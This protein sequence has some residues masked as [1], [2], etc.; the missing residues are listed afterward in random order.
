MNDVKSQVK[1]GASAAKAVKAVKAVKASD[2]VKQSKQNYE[3]KRD[4][5][6]YNFAALAYLDSWHGLQDI[7]DT[8]EPF[9]LSPLHDSDIDEDGKPKK[10]HY[11][12][13]F[14][15]HAQRSIDDFVNFCG[16]HGLVPLRNQYGKYIHVANPIGYARYLIH[17][18][19]PH[20][21]QYSAGEVQQF[22]GIQDYI[23]YISTSADEDLQI[24]LITLFI[25]KYPFCKT[26]S[27]W[28]M[29][30]FNTHPEWVHVF[31]TNTIYFKAII[32]DPGSISSVKNA[33][34]LTE[35]SKI[36]FN[37]RRLLIPKI[38]DNHVLLTDPLTGEVVTE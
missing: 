15:F 5:R 13:L 30:F 11:H 9:Y 35:N 33:V 29:F 26:Y 34:G 23:T 38:V 12:I 27:E 4:K 7:L 28:S 16:E 10:P 3:K 37:D 31:R 32:A 25:M 17:I 2:S 36:D 8:L 21:F 24:M 19:Q 1:I 6:Y 20:K 14:K 22:N 18:D